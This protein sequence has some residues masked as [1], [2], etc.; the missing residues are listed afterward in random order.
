MQVE[1]ASQG[2]TALEDHL[3]PYHAKVDFI[4]RESV[5]STTL[6]HAMQDI[7]AQMDLGRR[8]QAMEKLATNVLLEVIAQSKLRYPF[9]ALQEHFP[10]PQVNNIS[11][12]LLKY[13]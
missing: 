11:S 3:N 6:D 13:R 10:T 5:I 12:V 9:H 2:F 4:V 7:I 8:N 1:N